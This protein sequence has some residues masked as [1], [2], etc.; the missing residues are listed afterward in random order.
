M[1]KGISLKELQL[2]VFSLALA[3]CAEKN[4]EQ[5]HPADAGLEIKI[6][7]NPES[8]NHMQIC[9]KKCFEPN[10]GEFSFCWSLLEEDCSSSRHHEWQRKNCH[11]FD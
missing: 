5:T 4:T 7:H 11:L 3:S 8:E 10:R 2:I 6:C 1:L 9:T